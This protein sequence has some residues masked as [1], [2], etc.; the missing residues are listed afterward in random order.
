MNRRIVITA[1]LIGVLCAGLIGFNFV[2]GLFSGNSGG[3]QRAPT[4]VETLTVRATPWQPSVD[5][6]GTARAARGTDVAVQIAGVVKSINFKANDRVKPR[7]LLVQID[8]AVERAELLSSQASVRLYTAQLARSNK[9]KAQGFVSQASYDDVRAQ[10]DVA[11]SNEARQQ[12]LIDQKAIN[13]PFA[14]VVGIARVDAGQYLIVGSVVATL[15]DLD[16]MKVDFTVPEQAAASLSMGQ[17]VSFGNGKTD[18]PFNGRIVGIDPK[19]DPASRLVAVQAE[20]ANAEG[21]LR[22]GSFLRIRVAMPTEN[23]VLALPQTAVIPSL[24]GDYVFVVGAPEPTSADL[25]ADKSGAAGANNAPPGLVARQRFVT[26]GRR[27]GDR[28]EIVH[29]LKAGERI[30][31]SGQNRLQDGATVALAEAPNAKA[32]STPAP[33]PARP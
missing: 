19:I 26:I 20:I 10:L 22:P 28:V 23:E 8:D 18:L 30:V 16:H 27:D 6:V 2:R 31:S 25:P 14:G 24:Y 13:A 21:R 32:A 4:A 1:I 12:A 9:L 17:P 11:K 5:A 7:Q 15:Q 3:M 29:G 33:V